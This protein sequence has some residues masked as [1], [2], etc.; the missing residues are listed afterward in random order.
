[1]DLRCTYSLTGWW[2]HWFP[3][4]LPELPLI[5]SV[6]AWMT[7]FLTD[8]VIYWL[9]DWLNYRLIYWQNDWLADRQTRWLS[10]LLSAKHWIFNLC[11]KCC[12]ECPAFLLS[13]PDKTSP[14]DFQIY[15][16]ACCLTGIFRCINLLINC[17]LE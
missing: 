12:L 4:W 11:I 3:N 17:W 8:M 5:H 6:P 16:H 7:K 10:D 9:C 13:W 15:L 1:M 14:L 2:T